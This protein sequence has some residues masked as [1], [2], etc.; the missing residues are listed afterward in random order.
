[1]KLAKK[2]RNE[3]GMKE[4]LSK[5][6]KMKREHNNEKEYEDAPNIKTVNTCC[7]HLEN[8]TKLS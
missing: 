1:M 5:Y 6:L 4:R 8:A 7:R 3:E 2:G